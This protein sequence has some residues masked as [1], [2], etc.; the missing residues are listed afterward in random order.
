MLS[1]YWGS[2]DEENSRLTYCSNTAVSI[3]CSNCK[4]CIKF[5]KSKSAGLQKY[6]MWVLSYVLNSLSTS[7]PMWACI[8]VLLTNQASFCQWPAQVNHC[9]FIQWESTCEVLY[10]LL[11]KWIQ[12]TLR[13][14]T[15]SHTAFWIC[16]ILTSEHGYGQ[17][18]LFETLSHHHIWSI[19]IY[20]TVCDWRSCTDIVGGSKGNL[21]MGYRWEE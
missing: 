20:G 5:I 9:I 13:L 7:V 21:E 1:I 4:H 12:E 14:F 17:H 15:T 10:T 19:G 18:I 6:S 2:I 8:P 11:G 16:Q 3:N